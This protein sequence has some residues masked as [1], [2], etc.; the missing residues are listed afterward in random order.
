MSTSTALEEVQSH[1]QKVSNWL[2]CYCL[3]LG[4][5]A[6]LTGMFWIGDRSD[7]HKLFYATLAL[8]TLIALV[9]QPSHLKTLLQQPL[10]KLFLLFAAYIMLSVL[11]ADTDDNLL[12]SIKRPLYLLMLLFAAFLISLKHPGRLERMTEI[13][14]VIAVL[15]AALSLA[16]FFYQGANGRLS[17]YGALYNPL[18]SAHVFG[19]FCAYWLSRWHL[20]EKATP[21]LPLTALAILWALL[22]FTGSRTPL[23]ALS[24]CLLWLA[25]C[26]WKRRI[27]LAIATAIGLAL[28]MK[29]LLSI[30]TPIE[31]QADNLLSRG[32]SYRPAIW[33]EALRQIQASPW[34]GLGYG[35]PQ[36]FRVEGLDFAL[37]DPH[38]IE[39]A[40]LFCGGIVGLTL[41]ML[42]YS[43]AMTYAWQQRRQPAT[44]IASTL[45][46]F[47]FV[48]GL[49][50]GEAFFSRPKEHWFLIWIPLALL[51]AT[52]LN[53]QHAVEK[54]H[55]TPEKA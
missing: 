29:A 32:L 23:L 16:Y 26:Q 15:A 48:A 6:L 50:E 2:I 31:L 9:L 28:L 42:M 25:I 17:G 47:G 18:L 35:H 53:H 37:A 11:W 49:T 1:S 36:V 43:Y 52:R 8:P 41:W 44:L 27:L 34:F 5:L 10:I 54:H 22:I 33:Q 46:V 55:G 19:F 12:S 21:L 14:A 45:V 51:A 3:P 39:L 38:N 30:A 20:E 4:W 7:Y 13:A 40:V 24:V